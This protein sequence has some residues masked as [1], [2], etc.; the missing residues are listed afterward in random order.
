[1]ISVPIEGR[2]LLRERTGPG[3]VNDMAKTPKHYVL[4]PETGYYRVE[5]QNVHVKVGTTNAVANTAILIGEAI[6]SP[7][8]I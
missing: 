1:L 8:T 4:N 2:M 5:G 3:S 7:L 6:K